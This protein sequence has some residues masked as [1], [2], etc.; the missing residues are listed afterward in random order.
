LLITGEDR[1]LGYSFMM[2][3]QAALIGMA[4]ACTDVMVELLAAW[5]AG[6]GDRFILLSDAVDAF[7][8]ATFVTPME[9]Y[10]QRMLWA[11]EAENVIERG[12]RDPFAP[13]MPANER[14]RVI[15]AVRALRGR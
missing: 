13:R 4:A 15:R 3:A 8:A 6:D 11:L 9:G 10:I 1:F 2:G 7:G 14:D 5:R 12:A